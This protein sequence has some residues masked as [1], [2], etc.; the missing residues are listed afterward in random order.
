[1]S[2]HQ[3]ISNLCYQNYIRLDT[4][5]KLIS[6]KCFDC[7]TGDI[8]DDYQRLIKNLDDKSIEVI[9][10]IISR[11]HI[12]KKYSTTDFWFTEAEK[13]SLRDVY[14]KNASNI[15]KLNNECFAYGKY[16]LPCNIISPTALYYKHFLTTVKNLDSIKSKHIIDVCGFIGDSALTLSEYSNFN[17]HSFEPFSPLY[18]MLRK[19]IKLNNLN[20]VIPNKMALGSKKGYLELELDSFMMG[21]KGSITNNES[22]K[23]KVQVITLDEY[24]EKNNLNV[25]V[26]KVDI[27]GAEQDFLKGAQQTI[28]NQKPVLLLSIYHNYDDF[29]NIKPL[30]ESWD[31]GYKFQIKKPSDTTIL[32]DTTLVCQVN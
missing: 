31:L 16:L 1:M 20:N 12:Y 19:T 6:E 7:F 23:E 27:E 24:V 5:E 10:R 25:G 21:I 13:I 22:L 28:K 32:I 15:L 3:H 11:I 4:C 9:T 30:I 29:F 26:I 18:E 2:E 8:K 14:D 17:V